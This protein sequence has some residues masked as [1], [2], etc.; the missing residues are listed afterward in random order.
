MTRCEKCGKEIVQPD[1]T[2]VVRAPYANTKMSFCAVCAEELHKKIHERLP[3]TGVT[4]ETL[5]R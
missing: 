5:P 3:F 4:N 2:I 1:L